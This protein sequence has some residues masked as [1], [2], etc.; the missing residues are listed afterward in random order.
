MQAGNASQ[1]TTLAAT[2][3]DAQKA[4]QLAH[5]VALAALAAL[6]SDSPDDA[7]P[8]CESQPPQAHSIRGPPVKAGPLMTAE[9]AR[10][11]NITPGTIRRRLCDTGSYFGLVPVKL[12]SGRLMWPPD[13]VAQLTRGDPRPSPIRERATQV[14][15]ARD[16]S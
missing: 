10:E 1:L 2:L 5:A 15:R 7:V 11:L 4:F 12:A 14:E 16:A 8:S 13:S 6:V 3:R 9:L